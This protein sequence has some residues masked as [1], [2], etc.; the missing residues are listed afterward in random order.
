MVDVSMS[1]KLHFFFLQGACISRNH[2]DDTR[3]GNTKEGFP[4]EI[5]IPPPDYAMNDDED[6]GSTGEPL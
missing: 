6:I 2:I 1:K 5:F 4:V 3:I